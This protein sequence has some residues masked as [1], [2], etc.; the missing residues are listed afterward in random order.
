MKYR[1]PPSREHR[2][3]FLSK[4][5]CEV[6]SGIVSLTEVPS[7]HLGTITEA[8]WHSHPVLSSSP[9]G[10]AAS[11]L[12]TGQQVHSLR[13]GLYAKVDHLRFSGLDSEDAVSMLSKT[14][15]PRDES[16]SPRSDRRQTAQKIASELGYLTLAIANT[17]TS[18]RRK[19]YTLEMYLRHYLGHRKVMITSKSISTSDQANIITTWKMPC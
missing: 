16:P 10:I 14:A 1:D 12:I 4:L 15:F 6:I 5:G 11:K 13:A 18:I 17:G 7:R 19:I 9:E 8:K 2:T 3:H